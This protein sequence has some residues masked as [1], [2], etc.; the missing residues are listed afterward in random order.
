MTT[1]RRSVALLFVA[2]VAFALASASHGATLNT[3]QLDNGACGRNLQLGSD[4]TSSSSA[5]PSFLI[6]GD[7]GLSRYEAFVDGASIGTFASDGFA[8][9][10]A[11]DTIPLADGPHVLTA[12]ELQPH[13]GL[14]V[15]PFNFTVD[16]VPPAQ[17]STPVISGFSDSGLLGDHITRFRNPN[18]TGFADPKVAIQL[19]SGQVLLGGAQADVNGAWSAT[20][21]NLADGSYVITA[22]ALDQAGNKSML[23]V[24]CPLTVDTTLP[25]G[26]MTNPANGSVVTGTVPLTAAGADNT[27]IWKVDF[28]VDGV[29]KGTASA[30]PFSFTWNSSTVPNGSHTL[31]AVVHDYP[32]NVL[33]S[34]ITVNVQNGGATAPGAPTLNSATGA[35]ASATLNW[36][37]PASNGGSAIT[38]YKVYRG[39]ASGG[40][41][42]LTTLGNV[43]SWSDAGLTNGVP[44]YYKVTAVNAVG[45]SLLSNEVS[46][47]PAG[48]PGPPTLSAAAASSGSVALSWNAPSSNGGAG[49]TGY[50]VYRG[51]ASGGEILLTT[52]GAVTSWSDIGLANGTTYYYRVTA[53]NSVGES[54]LSNE[55]SATPTAAAT[56]PGAPTLTSAT[57]GNGTAALAWA[58]PASNGSA[59]TGYKVYRGTTSGGETLLTTLGAVTSWTDTG[60]A[61]N[62]TYFYKVSAVNGVGESALSGEKSATPA[63][64]PGAPTLNSAVGGNSSVTLNWAAPASNGGSAITG[65]K[66]YRGTTSGGET[67]LTTLGLVT[68]YLDVAGI[69]NGTAYYY[70]VTAV[71][72]AGEGAQSNEGSAIPASAPGAPT[73]NSATAG[74]GTVA[75]AWSAPT[76]NGGAGITGYRVYR[77]TASGGETFLTTLGAV[78][79]FTDATVANG[80]TYYYK[81]SALNSVGE[82]GLS[83]EQFATP[84]ASATVP[85]APTLNSATAGVGSVALNWSAPASDGGSAVSGYKVWRGTSS[86]GEALLTTLGNVT[87]WTDAGVTSGTTYY[88]KVSALNAVGESVPSGERFATPT[89]SATIPGAPTLNS[90]TGGSGNI[91]LA[92][93]PPASN[94]GSAITGYKIWRATTSGGEALLT[95]LGNVTGWTDAGVSNGTTY[96]YKVTA[97]NGI[98]QSVFSNERLATAGGTAASAPGAPTLNSAGG[99][100][101]SVVLSWSAPA[102][103]GGAPITGYKVYRSIASGAETL[104]TTVGNVTG[105][106]D[107][108]LTNGTA[109]YYKV[110]AVNSVGESSL[111][112]ERS[113]IPAT[114]P[115]PPTLAPSGAGNGQVSLNWTAPSSDGGSAVTGYKL[116]RSTASGAETLLVTLGNVT[117]YSDSGLSNGTTYYYK[118]GAVNALG[119]SVLSTEQSATPDIAPGAPTLGSPVVGNGSV[120][121]AW[122]APLSNGGSAITSYRV[123]RG[124]TSGGET[125]LTTLGN[126]TTYTD[127]TAANGTTYYY[128]VS[129]LNAK[130]ESVFSAEQS[131]TPA[132]VP[133][134]PTLNSATAA[135]GSVTLAWSAPTSDG[136]AGITGY[137]VY[138]GTTSG[139]E[140]L[141]TTVGAATGF[142]DNAVANGTT[143]YY[144]VS[145]LNRAGES[146]L[147]IEKFATPTAAA[148]VPGPATLNSATA[149]DGSVV[150]AWSAPASNGGAA[151]TGYKVYRGTTSG[152]ETLL[153][154]L[155]NVTSYSDT[156]VVNGTTYFYKVSAVNSVGEGSLSTERFATPTAAAT[157]P[158][159][160]TLN[161][162]SS[163]NGF[164]A[165]AW[166]APA[167]NGG[168]AITGYRVY[169]GIT[170]GGET[171]LTT[172]GNVTNWSD[173]SVVNGTTYYYVVSAVNAAGEGARSGEKSALPATTPGA[174]SLNLAVPG[175]SVTLS[176][177]APAVNGGLAVTGYKIY[178]GTTSTGETLLTTLGNVTSYTDSTTT[179]GTTYYFKISALN[180][181]G[182][183]S[184]S[185]ELSATPAAGTDTTPPSA[186]SNVTAPLVGTSQVVVG[187]TASTDNVG[188]TG[189]QV[190]RDGFLVGTV[191]TTRYLDSGMSAGSL[192]SY[193]VRAI[194]GAALQSAASTSTAATLEPL[195]KNAQAT[196]SGI[197]YDSVGRAL[198]NV[199]VTLTLSN[200]TAKTATTST[201]GVWTVGKLS[202]GSYVVTARLAGFQTATFSMNAAARETLLASTTLQ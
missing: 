159:P 21:G 172:L 81:V 70:K 130:G 142:T 65:Y 137:K 24:N 85:A 112:S 17:P 115:N 60:V 78:T 184:L 29:T 169:R 181:M 1:I 171:L 32:D 3:A 10:C 50:R 201:N 47:V 35:N 119:D 53:L 179:P 191:A 158:G 185:N 117:S 88:Y 110:S 156:S 26:G 149:G 14:T 76:S 80:T 105:F 37:A 34:T 12:N 5:A 183:S 51:T 13:A 36:A 189:Y 114:V 190:Y 67:L 57:A 58:A 165:L 90:A 126:V 173:T 174:P 89:A 193:Q 132:T 194:D 118:V 18:F 44:Y 186:P 8:N 39:T 157:V 161:S 98:G 86:G 30:S 133:G 199:A 56:V 160:A 40:E 84:A 25:T 7:G 42:L 178:R 63:G 41:A 147:S 104:L 121:L 143:Y 49:I 144:K 64:A 127:A 55:L 154:T 79:G 43:T 59:I 75:L 129:A 16:T 145:A 113:A 108:T 71:N 192:H 91:A 73:L 94:G 48:A 2:S 200:G 52:L 99:G 74:N 93:S 15:V 9:V 139:G 202:A 152:G 122:A 54:S 175:N 4:K 38:G 77:G 196:L 33:T 27:G 72:A 106:T 11:Y 148:T 197:V 31:T 46:A 107:G 68:T 97:V 162:A 6:A 82:G 111:S 28:Q 134:A 141:L 109:Y 45:E 100:N 146:S 101:A 128:K 136:G 166:S 195:G 170:S 120:A 22:V 138:R 69:Q 168:S 177:T 188:V 131:A 187:W 66:V 135:P 151:I 155:G 125:L 167:S 92:W 23:S 116:Y 20:L 140:T 163:G 150:L 19:Y 95:S 102:S 61:N 103:D 153:T 83:N 180:A 182:E 123:Y 124:T 62:T 198:P 164:V 87:G 96:Y 176:W